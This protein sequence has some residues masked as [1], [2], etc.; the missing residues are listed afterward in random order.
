MFLF[1]PCAENRMILFVARDVYY[2]LLAESDPG[3]RIEKEAIFLAETWLPPPSP[4]FLSSSLT[5]L[6]HFLHISF[7]QRGK[8][9]E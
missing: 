4:P 1:G 8:R 7:L 9:T 6:I 3:L 2:L 5:C